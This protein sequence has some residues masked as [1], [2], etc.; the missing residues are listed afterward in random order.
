[1]KKMGTVSRII[2]AIGSLAMCI[3]FFVPAWAIY[4]VAPQYPEGLSMQIWLYKIT[5]QVAII[6]GLNHYIGMK[7]INVDMF[8]EFTFLVY[9]L[10]FLVLFGLAVAISGSRKLLFTYLMLSIIGGVAALVDFY[11]W[12][13]DYGH[14]LDPSAAIQVAGLS[15][16]PPLIGHKKL[17]NFDAYS[18]PD[19]GGWVIV[20]V[21][22]LFFIIWFLEWRKHRKQKPMVQ[23]KPI[24]AVAVAS[25]VS[26]FMAGCNPTPEKIALGKDNCAE[27]KMTIMD[28][29]FGAEIVTKK[30]KVYKFDDTHCVAVFLE[31]RGVELTD[32][33][34]TLFVDYNNNN[35]FVKV[36]SVEFV[37]SSQ[38]KSPMGGNAAAFKN[39]TEA[40]KKSAEIEGSK[41]T[42]WATLYNILVK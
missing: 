27:C 10:G 14:N 31:R 7:P 1:M 5:G 35:E 23:Y 4:L 40:Q 42:N 33:H 8:P 9:I 20:V 32:I 38:F 36:K 28:P 16:Q 18:Y 37:V 12:G 39:T 17:L 2:I 41:V 34:Q 22:G 21:T 15:Y 25:I 6:N 30:G 11:M 29:K 3:M 26:F 19:T 13:Y 24:T